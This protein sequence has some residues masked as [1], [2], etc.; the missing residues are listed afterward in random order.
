MR[1]ETL[2]K[3]E[4]DLF[5]K[6]FNAKWSDMTGRLNALGTGTP[7]L[8]KGVQKGYTGDKSI[9]LHQDQELEEMRKSI[10]AFVACVAMFSAAWC[11]AEAATSV[12]P[13]KVVIEVPTAE[14]ADMW[15][16]Y[17]DF[18]ARL[19]EVWVNC[20]GRVLEKGAY[21]KAA[22]WF[23]ENTSHYERI[24]KTCAQHEAHARKREWPPS[25]GTNRSLQ[26]R[27]FDWD[28]RSRSWVQRR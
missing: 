15:T 13:P 12:L 27:F 5:V 7:P 9:V 21:I 24:L 10:S 23:N 20:P 11:D 3:I 28:E 16:Q 2:K 26:D 14:S 8:D 22:K 19:K 4:F 6:D 17:P 25:P 1:N 18:F